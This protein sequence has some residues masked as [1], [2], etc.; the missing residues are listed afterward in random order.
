MVDRME[1]SMLKLQR[2]MVSSNILRRKKSR[3]IYSSWV[4][5]LDTKVA[6]LKISTHKWLIIKS[7][8]ISC[9]VVYLNSK[10]VE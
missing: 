1:V 3:R 8:R 4:T 9:R 5:I 2:E 10:G 7:R 6:K